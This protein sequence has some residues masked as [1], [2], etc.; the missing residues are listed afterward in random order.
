MDL[1]YNMHEGK[2]RKRYFHWGNSW[3]AGM[4]NIEK[5]MARYS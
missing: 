3:K 2:I 5:V 1:T 4:W